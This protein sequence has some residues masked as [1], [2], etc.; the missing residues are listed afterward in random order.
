M[1]MMSGD[2]QPAVFVD[3][4]L[5]GTVKQHRDPRPD[6]ARFHFPAFRLSDLGSEGMRRWGKL[7]QDETFERAVQPAVEVLNGAT[8]FLEPQLMM[9]AISLERLGLYRHGDRKRRALWENIERCLVDADLDWPQLGS[10]SG[11]A[12]AIANLNNDLKH[13]DRDHFP[14]TDELAGVVYLSKIIIRAQMFD[15]L[16][17]P[18]SLRESF[19]ASNEAMNAV[20]IFLRVGLT[21]SDDGTVTPA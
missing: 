1:W 21:I 7:Y 3:V 6:P 19:V 11:I 15:L 9:L 16:G 18:Q 14:A 17:L 10:R 8:T 12:K 5:A 4:N 2:P 13:P 20:D